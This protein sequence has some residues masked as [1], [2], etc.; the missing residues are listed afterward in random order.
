MC[1]KLLAAGRAAGLPVIYTRSVHRR[2]GADVP[3]R[4]RRPL[5]S[6]THDGTT[7]LPGRSG[8]S[9]EIMDEVAPGSRRPVTPLPRLVTDADVPS[10]A[11]FDPPSGYREN[12]LH[13]GHR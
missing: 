12:S 6:V 2:D 4:M 10:G 13:T 8:T 11:V 1:R 7:P 3:P 9:A 5:A